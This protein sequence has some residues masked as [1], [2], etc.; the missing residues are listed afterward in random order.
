[1][2]LRKRAD[3]RVFLEADESTKLDKSLVAGDPSDSD[4][5]YEV[6][7]LNNRMKCLE[8]VSFIKIKRCCLTLHCVHNVHT[9]HRSVSSRH[10]DFTNV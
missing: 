10:M 9:M 6:S 8:L 2:P 1:M 3:G 7:Q 4:P 5:G